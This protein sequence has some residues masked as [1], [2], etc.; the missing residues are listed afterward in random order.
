MNPKNVL[1]PIS[2]LLLILAGN[3]SVPALIA[4]KESEKESLVGFIITIILLIIIAA[5]SLLV[6]KGYHPKQ[7]STKDGFLFVSLSWLLSAL[8]GCIPFIVSGTI[9]HF[10]DAFFETMS[11]F[12]TTGASILTEIETLPRSIL[13]WRSQTHWLGGMGIVVLAVAILPMLGIGGLQLIKA[14]A[15]GPTTDKLTP[16]VTETAKIL[17]AIYVGMTI[18]QTLLLMLGGLSLF[19]SLTHTFGTL[20][21][22]GFSTY[23]SSVGHFSSPYVH[24]IITI[25][26]VLAGIN[27]SLHFQMITGNFKTV[28]KDIEFLA[29]LSI[30]VSFSLVISFYLF[31]NHNE[32]DFWT[33]LRLSAFQVASILTTTGF[34]TSDFEMWPAMA[35]VM[36]FTLMFVGGCSGSTGGGIKVVRLVALFKTALNEMKILIHPRGIFR[37][38]MNGVL[39]KKEILYSI[40]GFFFIYILSLMITT[41]ITATSGVDSITAF[42]TSLATVGNIGPGFGLI[43]PTDNYAFFPAYVKLFLT[44][45]ML[46]GRLEMYTVLVILTPLFWKR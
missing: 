43:G 38:R 41:L 39:I 35:Q 14:E 30:F 21:T 32:T 12:T 37:V 9:P 33:S 20:A 25:F 34:A 29:Y 16:R 18:A 27:F 45:A 6:L 4:L 1:K 3:L 5:I 24:W 46:V 7:L 40:S 13:F 17:W 8:F 22:G 11:G 31:F 42:T 23:N 28:F 26:M 2:G 36:L 44:F 19:D 15:P 10:A